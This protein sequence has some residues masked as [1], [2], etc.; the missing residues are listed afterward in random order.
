MACVNRELMACHLC[1]CMLPTFITQLQ[2]LKHVQVSL[3]TLIVMKAS[4]KVKH[5]DLSEADVRKAFL[6]LEKSRTLN[7]H[8]V[9]IAPSSSPHALL[10]GC[11]FIK[12][13]MFY[14]LRLLL[15]ML[16]YVYMQFRFP[17]TW[18]GCTGGGNIRSPS[19]CIR[20]VR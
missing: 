8:L 4:H 18:P 10:G 13:L 2:Y 9:Q 6:Y 19:I 17:C 1:K 15:F 11:P 12:N 5:N 16:H 14:Q 20:C 7:P 3:S